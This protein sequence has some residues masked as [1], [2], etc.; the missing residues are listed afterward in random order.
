MLNGHHIQRLP[1][2]VLFPHN[3]CNCRCVMCDI[4]KIRQARRLTAADLAPHLDSLRA[5]GVRWVVYSGG[6][7]LLHRDL[8]PISQML[9]REGIRLTLLTAGLLLEARA[10]EVCELV[11]DVIVSLDGPAEVHD[12]IRGIPGAYRKLALGVAAVRSIRPDMPL[13]A[14]C[15]VQRR[16]AGHLAATVSAAHEL[17]LDGISFLAVDT[18]SEA[19][20]RPPGTALLHAPELSLTHEECERFAA[21]VECLISDCAAEIDSDFIRESPAKLRRLVRHFRAQ[22][23]EVTAVSPRCNAPWV[24]AVVEADGAVRPCFFHSP[25]GNLAQ[26]TLI[27]VLNSPT[28]V[29]FRSR[30]D[31]ASDPTCRHC[32]CSLYVPEAEP[33]N[34]TVK[35]EG[36][37]A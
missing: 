7:P 24:S 3:Q 35:R 36:A 15:T 16:N 2:L 22:L 29:E 9:R 11:D 21:H 34:P 17:D 6:E 30:L 27:Q 12:A 25:I 26:G 37:L 13:S 28:A 14:R 1:V 8:G 33:R 19:F 20:N 5:L 31:V 4:W 32:V 10:A 23:G 18:R